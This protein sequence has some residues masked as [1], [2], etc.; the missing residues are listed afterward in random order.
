M[1]GKNR[2]RDRAYVRSLVLVEHGVCIISAFFSRGTDNETTAI[3]LTLKVVRL[4]T[5]S[6]ILR[7]A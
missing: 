7:V 4:T 3:Y 5:V 1:G 2:T 6:K